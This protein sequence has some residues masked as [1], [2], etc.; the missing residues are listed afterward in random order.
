MREHPHLIRNMPTGFAPSREMFAVVLEETIDT[1][2]YAFLSA[3]NYG[4]GR[5][6]LPV[7]VFRYVNGRVPRKGFQGSLGDR[8]L[9]LKFS[10]L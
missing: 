8:T 5:T 4:V 3:L 2:A 10:T 6:H 9:N 7:C 1:F